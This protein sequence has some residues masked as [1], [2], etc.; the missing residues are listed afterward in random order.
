MCMMEGRGAHAWQW[1]ACVATGI[2]MV[3]G[4]CMVEGPCVVKGVCVAK[5]A[6]VHGGYESYW[7]VFLLV[8]VLEDGKDLCSYTS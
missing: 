6:C 7:N 4:V 5:G 2:C 1:R 8:V 3:K